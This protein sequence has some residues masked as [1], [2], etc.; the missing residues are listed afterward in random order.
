MPHPFI[1]KPRPRQVRPAEESVPKHHE[2]P[3]LWSRLSLALTEES[4]RSRPLSSRLL[5]SGS[6]PVIVV[7]TAPP[8]RL[9]LLPCSP[10]PPVRFRA[11]ISSPASSARAAP[12]PAPRPAQS[13]VTGGGGGRS[14]VDSDETVYSGTQAEERPR[15]GERRAESALRLDE[16]A[17]TA[18]ET[19]AG[20]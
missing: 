3:P 4:S 13:A 5:T 17:A 6:A 20:R 18:R 15:P 7:P 10:A 11:L 16:G 8:I 9:R 19:P 1:F 12:P 2:A 14:A